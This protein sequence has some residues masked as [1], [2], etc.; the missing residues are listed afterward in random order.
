M[1]RI[2]CYRSAPPAVLSAGALLWM[3]LV[4][5]LLP[6]LARAQTIKPWTPP[7][8]SFQTWSKEARTRFEA[9]QGDSVGGSN[10]RG[11]ELVGTI[12]RRLLR[13]LGH[14]N[15]VQSLAIK[16][17]LDSLGLDTDV[18]IDPLTPN[19]TLVM[20][21]NPSQFRA[22]AVGYLYWY[23][24]GDLRMQ[25]VLFKGG[26][27]PTMRAWWTGNPAYPYEWAVVDESPTTNALEFTLFR[28]S[29]SGSDWSIQQD[30]SHGSM[31]GEP[32]KASWTDVNNDGSPEL[33]S[34][35]RGHTDSLFVECSDCPR[36][37]TERVYTESADGF[38]M[39]DARLLPSP[40]TSFVLFV[41]LLRDHNTTAAAR[42]LNDPAR[43]KDAIALGFGEARAHAGWTVEYGESGEAWP[44]WLA[45]RLD[46][47]HGIKRYIV[48]FI[49]RDGHWLIHDWIEP[50]RELPK[51][52]APS[53]VIPEGRPA[54]P[55]HPAPRKPVTPRR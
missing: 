7:P 27:H 53:V 49:Q 17:V 40:Y 41:R 54:S 8:D 13:S 9:N 34:W 42:L 24:G 43:I 15:L 48:H 25:G 19:F 16:P 6:A 55:E 47:P 18:V 33:V 12:S 14:G 37:L 29:A 5:T 45:M 3:L 11:Y 36:L 1:L 50:R 31:L 52:S 21:R 4:A 39:L 38:E 26:R 28:L 30:E 51:G 2:P 23:R 32:G 46:S 10:Y 20:V 22:P 44:H 35:T